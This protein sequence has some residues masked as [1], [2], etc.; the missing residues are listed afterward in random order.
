MTDQT[1]ATNQNVP[2][3]G[4]DLYRFSSGHGT[5]Y[6]SACHG[7]PHAEYPTLQANDG[8]YPTQMQG[9]VAKI[10]ECSVCHTN[11]PVTPNGGPHGIHTLGQSWVDAHNDYAQGNLQACAY[12]HGV[13]FRGTPLSVSKIPHTFPTKDGPNKTFPAGHQ[14]NCYDCHNGPNPGQFRG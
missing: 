8:V 6:C 9:Y 13:D 2:I 10:T 5:V 11:V 4:S 3:L 12:C 1:F 7:S 14:F